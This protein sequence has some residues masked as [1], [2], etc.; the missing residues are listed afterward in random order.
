MIS[1][2]GVSDAEQGRALL[3]TAIQGQ[4][5]DLLAEAAR[6]RSP[7]GRLTDRFEGL[8]VTDAY[9]IQLANIRRRVAEGAVVRGH[10]VGLSSRSMQRL[11]NVHEPDYGHLLSDMFVAENTPIATSTMCAPRVEVEMAFVLR[12]RLPA[13]G[14]T[15]ADVLR[16]TAFVCPALEIIDSRIGEWN[17]SLVDTIADNASSGLVVLG[18]RATPVMDLDLRTVGAALRINGSLV[19]TGA[20]G[21]VL[22]N[23]AS[24]VAWLANKVSTFGVCLDEGDVILPGSCTEAYDVAAGQTVR[25]EFDR[26]G[27]VCAVFI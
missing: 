20:S 13:P 15:V 12:H 17:L 26:L 5:A 1:Y 7:I 19:A 9:E 14:C 22:G 10:K 16:C 4:A 2:P 18:G 21:A 8:S 6:Q 23:P 24:A 27:S 25:A 11:M 3:T